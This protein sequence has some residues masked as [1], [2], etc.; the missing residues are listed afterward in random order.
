M[1]NPPIDSVTVQILPDGRL[2]SANTA[3]YLGVS[4]KLLAMMRCDG[5][6]PLFLKRRGKVFYFRSDLDEWLHQAERVRSTEEARL[7][8]PR[9]QRGRA[10]RSAR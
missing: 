3:R 2:D 7:K 8:Q 4:T 9:G 5:S 6:G 1:A 10:S